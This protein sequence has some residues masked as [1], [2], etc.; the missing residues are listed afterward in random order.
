MLVGNTFIALLL[1]SVPWRGSVSILMPFCMILLYLTYRAYHHALEESDVWRQL[2]AAARELTVLDRSNVAAAAVA[3]A[4]NLF[5]AEFAELVLT[6]GE[7]H[8]TLVFRH[9]RAGENSEQHGEP[10]V[11]ETPLA[12]AGDGD[13]P[14]IGV[15]RLGVTEPVELS[16]RQRVV[17]RTFAHSVGT[18]LQNAR[19]YAE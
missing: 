11:I 16:R 18:S 5:N 8:D 4:V 14:V 19:L 9:E 10:H 1:V 2:D 7:D 3:R 6:S 17:L 13:S 15:L 12:V